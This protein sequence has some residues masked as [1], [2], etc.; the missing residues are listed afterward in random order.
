[1]VIHGLGASDCKTDMPKRFN[2]DKSRNTVSGKGLKL[3]GTEEVIA[4]HFWM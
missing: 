4:A 3:G 2:S 1:M